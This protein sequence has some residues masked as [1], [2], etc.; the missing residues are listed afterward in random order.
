MKRLGFAVV[1]LL[2]LSP[3]AAQA[4]EYWTEGP[5]WEVWCAR[6]T[7]G[8]FDDYIEYLQKYYV[9]TMTESKAQG[10]IVDFK[11]FLHNPGGPN[12]P[13]ICIATLHKNFAQFD[14]SADVEAKA[15]A[16]AAKTHQTADEKKQEEATAPRFQIRTDL[17]TSLYREVVLKPAKK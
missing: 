5:V 13:D 11:F 10:L 12:E 14:Y 4:Q 6:T 3:L 7:E 16:I 8:H 17:G 15:K 9:P 1:G 2:L